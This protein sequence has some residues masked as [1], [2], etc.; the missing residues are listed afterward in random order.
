MTIIG[1]RHHKRMK[2]MLTGADICSS[3][4]IYSMV[5]L[6]HVTNTNKA[7]TPE[8]LLMPVILTEHARPLASVFAALVLCFALGVAL[9]MF[10]W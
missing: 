6:G 9:W 4:H 10:G 3:L 7:H 1:R 2:Q 8:G 5:A